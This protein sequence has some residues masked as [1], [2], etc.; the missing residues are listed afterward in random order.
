[1]GRAHEVRAASMA[2]TAAAKSK[3]NAKWGKAI[4][5]AAKSGVPDP[6]LNQ[7]LKKEIEKAKREQ[8]SAD[9]IKRAIE[10]AKGGSTESYTSERYEGFGPGNSMWIVDCLTDNHNRTLTAVRTAFS[11]VGGNLGA[12]GCVTHMFTNQSVFSFE[13]EDE[14]AV[15]EGL[16][17]HDCEV[18]DIQLE[19][20]VISVFAPQQ[21][22]QQVRD[23]LVAL[24]PNVEFLEDHTTWVP[25]SYVQ[26]AEDHDK[27]KYERFIEMLDDCD[28]VQDYYH[29]IKFDEE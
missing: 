27:Q 22:Y 21:A 29:N 26:L 5:V 20:G 9:V 7:T 16:L 4:F 3:L 13:G 10:K 8:V 6:E 18:D 19:D 25:S 12:S 1:M 24:Y 14:E 11:R 2:K 23:A 15:L 17:E 28:D